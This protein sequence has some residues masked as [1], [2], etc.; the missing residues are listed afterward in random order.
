MGARTGSAAWRVA[1]LLTIVAGCGPQDDAGSSA[2][3]VPE[4]RALPVTFAAD[5]IH[6]R[7]P[8]AVTGDTLTFYTDTGGGLFLLG[9]AADRVG[10]GDSSAVRL[11]AVAADSAFPDPRGVP[12]G[13]VPV[14]RPQEA[15]PFDVDGMLGQAWFADRVWTF[16]YPRQTLVLHDEAAATGTAVPLAFQAD[17][18]GARTLSFP[19][20]RVEID[21]DS[22]D[23]L[24]D[25]GATVSLTD[26][27]WAAL[28]AEGPRERGTSFITTSVLDR[29]LTRHPDWAWIP[30]GDRNV[31]GSRLVRVPV[32]RVAGFETGP[33]W[34]TERPDRNFREYMAQFMDRPVDGA[35]GGNALRTFRVTVDYP[36]AH[37]F[38]AR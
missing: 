33:V 16:D 30:D 37:A 35:L 5:R 26:S 4:G 27:A 17:S 38:F 18:T 9:E 15:P 25:T 6:L 36:G 1:A 13:R 28:G 14:F 2:G 29:W 8:L 3:A 21:G 34:F 20:I 22:L 24:F 23:L 19:R 11:S 31:A 7:L 10:L 32:V 12:E